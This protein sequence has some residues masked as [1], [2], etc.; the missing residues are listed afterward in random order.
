MDRRNMLKSC[1]A[2][3]LAAMLPWK[4]KPATDKRTWK[5]SIEGRH[6]GPNW[7]LEVTA[8]D[9]HGRAHR[10]RQKSF[11]RDKANAWARGETDSLD[12]ADDDEKTTAD[13]ELFARWWAG[14]C[15][16]LNKC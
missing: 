14:L 6:P 8:T 9:E 3:A 7:W 10:R 11:D 4:T 13:D 12:F 1:G 5:Y 15:R 2:V 16:E